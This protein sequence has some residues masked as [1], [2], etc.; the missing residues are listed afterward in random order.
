MSSLLPAWTLLPAPSPSP[1]AHCCL[2]PLLAHQCTLV[3]FLPPPLS[4]ELRR[5][6][7]TSMSL[8]RFC[9]S[10]SVLHLFVV[11]SP[12][13]GKLMFCL[14][15]H[16]CIGLGHMKVP[17]WEVSHADTHRTHRHLSNVCCVLCHL[18]AAGCTSFFVKDIVFAHKSILVQ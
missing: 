16:T 4:S 7:P 9:W 5:S 11:E 15:H 6:G 12:P 3:P 8:G 13:H 1:S 18:L 2:C 17:E 10:A 14:T